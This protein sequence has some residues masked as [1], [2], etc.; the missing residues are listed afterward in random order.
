MKEVAA[1][2]PGGES[3]QAC[4]GELAYLG[5][6]LKCLCTIV[7]EDHTGRSEFYAQLQGHELLWSMEIWWNN[8]NDWSAVMEGCWS[9]RED[10]LGSKERT[11]YT[12]KKAG[13]YGVLHLGMGLELV[14]I[15]RQIKMGAYVMG[16]LL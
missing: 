1:L 13:M 2:Q 15:S 4:P 16:R 3:S 8:S 14:K 9:F 11:L 10:E 12:K 7:R 5:D 6:S